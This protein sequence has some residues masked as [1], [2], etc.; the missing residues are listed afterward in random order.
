M[1]LLPPRRSIT[2]LQ[3][4]AVL[5]LIIL[6]KQLSINDVGANTVTLS[7]TDASGNTVYSATAVVTINALPV[8]YNVTGGGAYCTGTTGVAVGLSGSQTGISYQL[9]RDGVNTGSAGCR[10]RRCYHFCIQTAAG[11]Y[12][13]NA[14]NVSTTCGAAMSGSSNIV[15]NAVPVVTITPSTA[16][17]C[18][19]G[20]TTLTASQTITT[21]RTYTIALAN[22]VNFN[23]T[24]PG[25]NYANGVSGMGFKWTDVGTGTVSN[26]KVQLSSGVECSSAGYVHNIYLNSNVTSASFSA[27]NNCVCA[28]RSTPYIPVINFIPANYVVGG[29]NTITFSNSGSAFGLATASALSGAYAIVTVTYNGGS[30][31]AINNWVWTPGGETTA[32]ISVAPAA[33]TS[34]SVTGTD[35]NGCTGT[36]STSITVNPLPNQYTVT[37]GG[38]GCNGNSVAI[39]LSGSQTNVR[40]QLMRGTTAVGSFV[41][42]TGAAINFAAQS[43]VGTY[44]VVATYATTTCTSGM[45]GS[46]EVTSGSTPVITNKVLT[47]TANTTTET[48]DATVSYALAVSG[49]PSPA[50]S[51]VFTGATNG[52]GAGTGSGS[53]FNRGTTHVVVTAGNSCGTVSYGFDVVVTDNVDPVI[54]IPADIAVNN[55]INACGATI[56]IV[57]ATATDNCTVSSVTGQ[58]SDGLALTAA[59]PIGVT[60][61]P[62]RPL[63]PAATM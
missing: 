56:V 60:V 16:T 18:A 28:L 61:L 3:T 10:Y 46:V 17:I 21:T 34:Y 20:T 1:L 13:V 42:G 52:A 43:A 59:Y 35:I 25:G 11:V 33:T 2:V 8:V 15:V 58:R 48:C 31:S 40:Y 7:V 41:N 4:I 32:S 63:T 44:T 22:L 62:G 14:T 12:T 45:T 26:V 19:G 23:F 9:K 36:A 53:V 29:Q 47:V 37:G 6:I 51:Y 55:D 38:L 5:F 24:C 54:T 30:A 50:V 39:G 57:D 49:V 27:L